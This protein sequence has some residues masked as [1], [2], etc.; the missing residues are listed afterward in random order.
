MET[1]DTIDLFRISGIDNRK[2][3]SLISLWKRGD[4]PMFPYSDELVKT[5]KTYMGM[6]DY[7]EDHFIEL[8]PIM[9]KLFIVCSFT[10]EEINSFLEKK[11]H[12]DYTIPNAD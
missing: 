12:A 6:C 5:T 10:Q 3:D 7:I 2:E 11:K 9:K 1:L 4:N 8:Q